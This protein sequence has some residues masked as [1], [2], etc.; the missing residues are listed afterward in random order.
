[1]LAMAMEV[2]IDRPD[3][4]ISTPGVVSSAISKRSP[5]PTDVDARKLAIG[6]RGNFGTH[7]S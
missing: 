3:E 5:C 1:M 4:V 6:S 7:S 2:V